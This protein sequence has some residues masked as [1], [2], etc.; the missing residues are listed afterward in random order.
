MNVV[1]GNWGGQKGGSCG[2]G[3]RRRR[4]GGGGGWSLPTTRGHGWSTHPPQ[5]SSLPPCAAPTHQAVLPL[6]GRRAA[7]GERRWEGLPIPPTGKRN[8]IHQRQTAAADQS[9]CQGT[10][11]KEA[12]PHW[13][14]PK[15]GTKRTN[16]RKDNTRTEQAGDKSEAPQT[17]EQRKWLICLANPQKRW[18]ATVSFKKSPLA[19]TPTRTPTRGPATDHERPRMGRHRSSWHQPCHPPQHTQTRSFDTEAGQQQKSS[20]STPNLR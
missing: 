13:A 8:A 3:R 9:K 18:T 15:K 1:R 6:S 10:Q 7:G 12:S 16:K 4:G 11:E 5:C 2:G 19:P 17:R 20:P 14:Y